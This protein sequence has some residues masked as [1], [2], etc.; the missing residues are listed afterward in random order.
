MKLKLFP[1]I[2]LILISLATLPV[3]IVGWQ[4]YTLNKI[5]LE[6]NILELH[7][8]L[9]LSL[10]NRIT[11][12]LESIAGRTRSVIESMRSQGMIIAEPLQA[13]V[14]SNDEFLSIAYINPQGKE[15]IK[16]T[17][18]A[19][20]EEKILK[21]L[22][23]DD[24]FARY[25]E[26]ASNENSPN[27][28]KLGFYYEK[29][30]P[31]LKMVFPFDPSNPRRGGFYVLVSLEN[32]WQQIKEQGAG[33]G[34][35]GREAFVIDENGRLIYHNQEEKA[36]NHESAIKHP[37]VSEALM[38]H[39]IGSKEFTDQSGNAIVGAYA[40]V[41]GTGWFSIIQQPEKSAYYPIYR[42]RSRA[43][44]I[45]LISILLASLIAFLFAKN[46][47]RPIFSLIEGA[48]KVATGQF[49]HFVSVDTNDE[50]SQLAATFNDMVK[51]LKRYSDLQVDRMMEEKTKTEAVIFSIAD[52]LVLTNLEGEIQLIND[53]AQKIFCLN[54]RNLN[55]AEDPGAP[56]NPIGRKLLDLIGE[57]NLKGLIQELLI[58]PEKSQVKEL[59]I[60]IASY[61]EH[62][63]FTS[64]LVH[65]P[66]SDKKI[67][68]VTVVHDV[69]LER[70]LDE[71]KEGFLH[72]ITHDLRN[73]MTSILGFLKF[74][75]DETA[76]PT[77]AQQKKMLQV[78]DRA[79]IRLLGMINDIL[80][81]AKI[82]A[83]KMEIEV[84]KV[85]LLTILEDIHS[86]YK[87]MA[88][89]KS[90]HLELHVPEKLNSA[91]YAINAD[92]NQIERVIGNLT[93]NA[94]KFTPMD[95]TVTI[96]LEDFNERVQLSV[97]DTGLGVPED[98]RDKIFDKFQQV[99]GQKKGGT[100]LEI[101]RAHV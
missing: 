17:N 84:T 10:S 66:R 85:P 101:G 97:G 55:S 99:K 1:K 23:S 40:E 61:I 2:A 34:G 29:N 42:T 15:L 47:S 39:S 28:P 79:S 22:S 67:G 100:G 77:N 8:N 52:G 50:I 35:G 56:Q 14:N 74:L 90:I 57:Q 30:E 93:A 98:Y 46:L 45:V 7:T 81:V 53:P 82:E 83:G 87:P 51:E 75:L 36:K 59:P 48:K 49:D 21:D 37:I 24:V 80:D 16:V 62:H 63:Q 64:R 88:E 18:F 6:T 92:S 58:E 86:L 44:Q 38:R 11:L 33:I 19:Y 73:P 4:T 96:V 32:L 69:T 60:Q 76:G 41:S 95:G 27:E 78:M 72:S 3:M 25:K 31:R 94:L 9:A 68:V 26:Q 5:H 43:L 91:D 71:L 70:E 89:T 65:V 20:P 13:F 54:S 12:Y